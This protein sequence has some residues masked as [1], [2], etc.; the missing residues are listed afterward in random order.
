DIANPALWRLVAEVLP[1]A[2]TLLLNGL[3]WKLEKEPLPLNL[4]NRPGQAAG[5]G[6]LAGALWL[7]IPVLLLWATGVLTFQG[8]NAIDMLWVWW[9]SALLNAG[10]QE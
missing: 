1:L 5:I 10:M 8:R 3:F 9:L 6:G 2:V 7:G 4:W